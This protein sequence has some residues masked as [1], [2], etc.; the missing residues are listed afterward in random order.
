MS[1]PRAFLFFCV[2][3][4]SASPAFPETQEPTARQIEQTI[5]ALIQMTDAD[6]LAA[7]GLLSVAKHRDQALPLIGRA[8]AASPTRADLIWLQAE[9]CT[10]LG[11]C[12]PAPIENRLREVDP[13]NAAGWVGTLVRANSSNDEDAKDAAL[14]AIGHT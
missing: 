3:L 6:S 1:H 8:I 10:K 4:L 2:L 14:A 12:D 9:V 11:S 13:P 5:A 7:A